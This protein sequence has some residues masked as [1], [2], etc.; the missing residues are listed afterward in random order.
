MADYYQTLE[1]QKNSS[2]DDIKKSYRK[3]AMQYHPDRNPNDPSAEQKFKEINEAYETLSDPQKRKMYDTYGTADPQR[4]GPS[5]RNPFSGSSHDDFMQDI[6]NGFG[7]G[8]FASRQ[9]KQKIVQKQNIAVGISLPL[10][11]CFRGARKKIEYQAWRGC[12]SCLENRKVG[13]CKICNG[14]GMT[15]R[16]N[17]FLTE[18]RT[19]QECGGT[20]SRNNIRCVNCNNIGFKLEQQSEEFIIPK[21]TC[22]GTIIKIPGKGHEGLDGIGDLII[23]V[24]VS[25]S[26]QFSSSRNDLFFDY[27]INVIDLLV[28]IDYTIELPDK[29]KIIVKIPP[30]T[31]ISDKIRIKGEGLILNGMQGDLYV[32]FHPFVP[33]LSQEDMEYLRKKKI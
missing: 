16:S 20:G 25:N 7:L 26:R 28:G 23:E 19:C 33:T 24:S 6:L 29:E 18:R 3:K 4:G 30:G 22:T 27:K 2:E 11:E 31:Q 17:G 1:I 14:I 9:Q 32:R 15:I 12:S 10:E 5:V 13:L 8:G 21:R